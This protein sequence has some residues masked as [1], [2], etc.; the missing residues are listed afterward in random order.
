MTRTVVTGIACALLVVACG[1]GGEPSES[2]LRAALERQMQKQAEHN[3]EARAKD[4][5]YP[6]R[7]DPELHALEK[8]SCQKL[9]G[10]PV[11]Y[12]CDIKVDRT[13]QGGSRLSDS[14]ESWTF[15][16]GEDGW[17]MIL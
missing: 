6:F 15:A 12:R 14:K 8:V 4:P 5:N 13:T 16:E 7:T 9:E 17:E 11:K 10:D 1:K 3:A 2:D